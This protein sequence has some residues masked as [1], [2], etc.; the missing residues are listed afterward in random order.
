MHHI[1]LSDANI[2]NPR[3]FDWRAYFTYNNS[4]LIP[5]DYTINNEL[6]ADDIS[7]ITPSVCAFQIGEGSEGKH[8]TKV[9]A[10]FAEKANYPEYR[11]IMRWFI[12]EENRHSSML[13][14]YMNPY[15]ISTAKSLW[16]DKV[17]RGMR[18]LMGIWCEVAVLVTAEMIALSYYDALANATPSKQLKMICRQMLHDELRHVVL[19]SDTLGR[20]AQR[21]SKS[22]N[23]LVR[24]LRKII[25]RVTVFTVWHKYHA[26][27]EAGGWSYRDFH[28][29]SFAYLK[30][31]ILIEQT[32]AEH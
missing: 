3:Q 8:L 20:I 6:S 4:H 23:R 1:P 12:I 2:D 11:E 24:R 18:R 26:L 15:G 28:S 13:K 7:L 31:S 21:R 29:N 14:R 30:E 27:F 19:Q 25:M 10:R 5:V 9:A 22:V 32:A 16:I 17:F